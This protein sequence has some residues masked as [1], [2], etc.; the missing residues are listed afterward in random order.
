[1]NLQSILNK[2]SPQAHMGL[3]FNVLGVVRKLVKYIVYL[4][5]RKN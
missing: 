3:G 1:M 5:K 4:S 2:N